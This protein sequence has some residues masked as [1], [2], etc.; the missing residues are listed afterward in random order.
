MIHFNGRK[1][2]PIYQEWLEE[3]REVIK[4][5]IDAPA[6]TG[7]KIWEELGKTF[8]VEKDTNID[9]KELR[10]VLTKA[11]WA[12]QHGLC[13]YCGDEIKQH[14]SIE[15]WQPKNRF[16]E[17]T[18]DYDNLFLS[19]KE[20]K[21]TKKY[22]LGKQVKTVADLSEKVNL[23]KYIIRDYNKGKEEKEGVIW[24]VPAPPHCDDNKSK[25]DSREEQ[26]AIVYPPYAEKYKHLVAYT[27]DGKIDLK[28]QPSEEE[29]KLIK[30]TIR[31]LA[32]D[33]KTLVDRR[34]TKWEDTIINFDIL[35]EENEFLSE[36][37]ETLR[38]ALKTL[39]EKVVQPDEEGKLGAF[40]FVEV[41]AYESLENG[42]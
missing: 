6:K 37:V 17:R 3:N 13:C 28:G 1:I 4:K 29:A 16:K 8:G 19:C 24:E 21:I 31:V 41:A 26:I 7:T 5:W 22:T 33:C 34:K 42:Y 40:F 23:S 20:S 2:P 9:P 36:D 35:L 15:H 27:E 12:E 38:E 14:S 18:F 30:D 11:F 32:L 10:K 25:Y 39:K